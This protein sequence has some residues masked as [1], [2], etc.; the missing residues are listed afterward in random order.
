MQDRRDLRAVGPQRF[1]GALF[2][3][4]AD[5]DY[6]LGFEHMHQPREM[7]VTNF[8][9]L[10]SFVFGQLIRCAVAPTFFHENKRA[11]VGDVVLRK[12]AFRGFVVLGDVA[13]YAAA[14][15]FTTRTGK[16]SDRS[17]GVRVLGFADRALDLQ[18]I[19]HPTH[20]SK[21]NPRL[22]HAP[23]TRVHPEED[24]ALL[25]VRIAFDVLVMGAL[26]ICERV[27]DVGYGSRERKRG[28][29]PGKFLGRAANALGDFQSN[30][31]RRRFVHG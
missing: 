17:F 15:D 8:E 26:R 5:P 21:W 3:E 24:N 16:P 14:A 4:G 6:P 10:S 22:A 1:L 20:F 18:P 13:P 19:A 2:R 9:Q 11:V 7:T 12:E 28:D 29:F 31:E 25:G 30:L 27:V 23:W